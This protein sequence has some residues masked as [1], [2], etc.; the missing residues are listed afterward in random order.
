MWEAVSWTSPLGRPR[1]LA[2]VAVVAMNR[3]RERSA[4]A[5]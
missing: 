3:E 1:D 4:D 2:V 5:C